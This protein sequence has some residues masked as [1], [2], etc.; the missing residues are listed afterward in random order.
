[1]KKFTILLI[2]FAFAVSGLYAQINVQ[3]SFSKKF[4]AELRVGP[5]FAYS[6]FGNKDA[7]N[8]NSGFAK[9]GYKIE[10]NIGYKLIDIIGI[11]LMGF[12]N[13]NGTDLTSLSN[14]LQQQTGK[15]W[16]SDSKSW[17]IFGGLLGFE[18]SYP[19]SKYFIIGFKAYTG[20]LNTTAPR[21]ELT[22]GNDSYIQDE[23]STTALTYMFSVSGAYPITK[24]L[25]WVSSLGY[26]GSTPKFSDVKTTETING[27]VQPSNTSTFNQDLKVFVIDTGLRIVF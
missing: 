27:V 2:L 11:N 9:T 17:A 10:A 16:T 23:K 24:S 18:Y 20:I 14:L 3:S 8:T 1:M 21:V 19:A 22:S 25:F 12:Y 7:S 13:S 6:D 4:N 15:S 5:S 26:V